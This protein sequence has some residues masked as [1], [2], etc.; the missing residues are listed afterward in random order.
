MVVMDLWLK[1]IEPALLQMKSQLDHPGL[2]E[3][4]I[5]VPFPGHDV[6]NPVAGD[7]I[8]VVGREPGDRLAF[9]IHGLDRERT[10]GGI[11]IDNQYYGTGAGRGPPDSARA[12]YFNG[13]LRNESSPPDG[14]GRDDSSIR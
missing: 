1:R 2:K 12:E 9:A 14:C 4:A 13:R 7:G 3:V 10:A 11:R 8:T 6:P 5:W